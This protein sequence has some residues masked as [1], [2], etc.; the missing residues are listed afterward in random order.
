MERNKKFNLC[1]KKWKIKNVTSITYEYDT[2]IENFVRMWLTLIST[3]MIFFSIFFDFVTKPIK[4]TETLHIDSTLFLK[5]TVVHF[6][7]KEHDRG[8]S[9]QIIICVKNRILPYTWPLSCHFKKK[10]NRGSP[11][12]NRLVVAPDYCNIIHYNT[13]LICQEFSRGPRKVSPSSSIVAFNK[14]SYADDD[15]LQYWNIMFIVPIGQ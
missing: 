1:T 8:V 4:I 7:C 9:S 3:Y 11:S 14:V 15:Q 2:S 13:N 6:N 5:Y 10:L 12:D